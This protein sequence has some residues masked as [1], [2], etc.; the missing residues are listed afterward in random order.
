LNQH[1][2]EHIKKPIPLNVE[3]IMP[4]YRD[5]FKVNL[6]YIEYLLE[7]T[8]L[9][10]SYIHNINITGDEVEREVRLLLR[11]LLP[12]RFQVTHGY[13]ISAENIID[14]PSVSPQVDVIIVDTLVPHSI[15]V[16]DQDSGMQIFPCHPQK[17][18]ACLLLE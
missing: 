8:S 13:I 15:F 10:R 2:L 17:K 9:S 12:Q 4:S 5:I 3:N 7:K 1:Y 14:E 18:C 16:I 6:K 11:N